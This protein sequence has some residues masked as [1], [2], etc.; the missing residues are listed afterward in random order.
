[1]DERLRLNCGTI[2]AEKGVTFQIPKSFD[3]LKMEEK[4]ENTKNPMDDA[5]LKIT[6]NSDS[7]QRQSLIK[8]LNFFNH[9]FLKIFFSSLASTESTFA[10]VMKS[11]PNWHHSFKIHRRK[12]IHRH[13]KFHWKNAKLK[14]RF[15][16]PILLLKPK[17]IL[18]SEER[19]PTT[20]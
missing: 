5:K 16:D 10:L 12:K 6:V 1:M 17:L 7:A 9:L 13:W 3:K 15:F 14:L 4:S 20:N 11:F 19:F 2:Y 8:V 18:G